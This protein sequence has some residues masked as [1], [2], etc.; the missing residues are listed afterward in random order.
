MKTVSEVS[1]LSGVSVRALHHYDAIGLL[2]PTQ[3]TEAGYRLYDGAALRRLQLIL[4]FR[5]LQFPLR[6]IRTILDSPDFDPAEA[7]GQQIRL[8]ELRRQHLDALIRLARNLQKKGVEHMDFQA[9]QT[10]DLDQ[11]AQEVRA[12]WGATATYGEY[13]EKMKHQTDAVRREA[14]QALMAQFTELGALRR[15]PPEDPAVQRA[16]DA[17]QAFLTAHYF[18][19]TDEI[20]QGLGQMYAGDPRMQQSI[21]RAGGQ[22]TAAFV[23]SAI[24]ARRA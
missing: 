16:L 11:Y 2:K 15:L 3:V 20:F 4:L 6:E 17:L 23:R 18:Q 12:R 19:C 1:R 8:L 10:E 9:F 13:K 24:A 5:S 14:E 22:G 21:D 7:L